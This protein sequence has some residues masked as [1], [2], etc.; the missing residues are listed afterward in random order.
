MISASEANS[1]KN[2]SAQNKPIKAKTIQLQAAR[3]DLFSGLWLLFAQAAG[4]QRVD[5][6]S[7][8]AGDGH[9]DH[10]HRVTDRDR[11]ERRLR[12]PGHE[13]AVDDIV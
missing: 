6:D 2:A 1:D 10:L 3:N 5:P 9:H 7:G 4:K 8:A 13:H 12:H 11:I